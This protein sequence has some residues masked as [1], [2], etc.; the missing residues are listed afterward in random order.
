[1]G[2]DDSSGGDGGVGMGGFGPGTAS[3]PTGFSGMGAA[4]GTDG[5]VGGDN[6]RKL[7]KLSDTMTAA[8]PAADP[9]AA[10]APAALGSP[11]RRVAS[12][13]GGTGSIVVKTLLGM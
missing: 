4:T 5:G 6:P 2:G 8:A 9:V 7:K 12:S 1:M 13:Q 11:T 10:P 3:T